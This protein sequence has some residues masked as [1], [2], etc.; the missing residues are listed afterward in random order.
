MCV[1]FSLFMF[2]KEIKVIRQNG[3][4]LMVMEGR[5]I[6]NKHRKY[7]KNWS[8]LSFEMIYGIMYG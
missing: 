1:E 3:S 7:F 5:K 2:D 6:M 8:T 4:T